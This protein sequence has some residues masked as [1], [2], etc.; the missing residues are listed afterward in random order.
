M[1]KDREHKELMEQRLAE[2]M[3]QATCPPFLFLCVCVICFLVLL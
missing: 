1:E 2:R 3:E